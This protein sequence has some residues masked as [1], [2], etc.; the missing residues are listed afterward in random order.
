MEIAF[1]D[2]KA[3]Y[4]SIKSKIDEAVAEVINNTSFIG[5]G[6]AKEFETKFA[7][8][9]G[10]DHAVGCANGTDA[11]EIALEALG[12]GKGDEVLVP[13]Y[14]WVSTASA[15]SRVGAEPVFVDVHEDYYTMDIKLIEEA[16]TSKTKAIIPVHFYGL[17][18]DMIAINKIAKKHKLYVI[19]DCAQAHGAMIGKQAVG[20]FGD[21]ATFSF[22]P[23]KNLGAYGDGG[24]ILTNNEALA[25]KCRVISGL[26]QD[27]KHNHVIAGR[28]SR[29]DTLQ[30]AILSVKL[31]LLEEWT[32]RRRW[33]ARQYN[34][35]LNNS[36]VK[37]QRIP[38]DFK[39]VYHL[40]VIQVD[41]RDELKSFLEEN[42]VQT[43][44]H[45]PKPLNQFEMFK[46]HSAK[47]V[48]DAMAD[49]LLSLPMYAEMTQGQI[50]YI[51]KLIQKFSYKS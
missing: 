19:E 21:I 43:Q 28:N 42:G 13:A 25:H 33:V 32:A 6:K 47:K 40:Y 26:G 11:I 35:K 16:I 51:V 37:V 41:K 29:L 50:D 9:I 17:P 8:F 24:A 48:S 30:A 27:G 46:N 44:I 34:M 23:G 31:P 1:V 5:G 38:N 4:K 22:Y 10:V 20:S 39:H 49:R 12:V 15:V 14:T 7:E 45:Y 3:Q 18:A 2:L 36:K